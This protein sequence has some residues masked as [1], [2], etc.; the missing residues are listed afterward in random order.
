MVLYRVLIWTAGSI[1][2]V[3]IEPKLEIDF[4]LIVEALENREG[5]I[6]A[7]SGDREGLRHVDRYA[8]DSI[9]RYITEQP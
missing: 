5:W 9:V 7:Q 6:T 1:H 4:R 2:P 3:I 8:A